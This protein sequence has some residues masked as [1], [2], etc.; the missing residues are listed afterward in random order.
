MAQVTLAKTAGFCFGVDRAVKLTYSLVDSG[1]KVCTLGH[2][3][4]NPQVISDLENK[5]VLC[6]S[7]PDEAKKGSTVVIRAHGVGKD[8]EEKLAQSGADVCDATCP[9]VEKIHRIVSDNSS[10][11]VPVIIIGDENHPEVIGIKGHCNGEVYIF[12]SSEELEKKLKNDEDFCKNRIIVVSQTTFSKKEWDFCKK[13]INLYCT[14][15]KIF[16]TICHATQK[17]QQEAYELSKKSDVMIIIGGRESSNTAKL[18][19]VCS[20]NCKT[21]LVERAEELKNINFFRKSRVGVT[22][23]AST[24]AEIIKEVLLAM[25]EILKTNNDPMVEEVPSEAVENDANWFVEEK[26]SDN[27]VIKCTVLGITPTEIQVDIPKNHVLGGLTG[28]VTNDEYSNDPN[29]NPAKELK[30]G[31]E[32]DLVIMKKNDAEGTVLLS[33]KRFDASKAW[34]D[35][36]AAKEADAVLTGVVTDVI[37][38]GILVVANNARVFIPASLATASRNDKLEDLLKQEVKFKI[39]DI[40]KDKK[41]AKGSVR[42]ILKEE[43]KAAVENFWA[44]AP[45]VGDVRK[46]VVKSLTDYGAFVD[47]G[48]VDGMVHISD[49]SWNNIKHPSEVVKVGDEIE[50]AIKSLD[51]ERKRISLSFK[52]AEDNP[53]EIMK[54]DYPVGTVCDV[55]IANF[56]DFGAFAHIIPRVDGL[57]HISQIANKRIGKPSDVLKI[58]EVVQAKIINIDFDNKKV[59]LSIRA[60]LPEEEVEEAVAEEAPAEET[61]AEEAV[62]EEVVEEKVEE[63]ADAE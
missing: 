13:I 48:G 57:I 18:K 55:T 25:S 53:W 14:N 45:E 16:D 24:P 34:E 37:R 5:G 21:Y 15:A 38:G 46:G 9:F 20:E 33:K 8:V 36:V 62:A 49:L 59:S 51:A 23:G 3:I 56:T 60:L 54:R 27:N 50:V 19:A 39:I 47:I 58:G 42:A 31:D 44:N 29:A 52:K 30:I 22:A 43:R 12:S 61:V 26:L 11:D 28:L 7:S 41:R 4:H 32:I 35:L 1:K 6:I 63:T 10:S 17:R 40:D 2:I